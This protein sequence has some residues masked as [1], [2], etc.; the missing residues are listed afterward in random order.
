MLELNGFYDDDG[1]K[2][3]PLTVKKPGLCLL[4]KHNYTTED[5]EN[6]LCMMTRYDQR[7]EANFECGAFEEAR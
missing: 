7:N 6:T 3:N 1:K 2:L 4:C 5:I